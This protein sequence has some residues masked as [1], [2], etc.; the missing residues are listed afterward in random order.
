M[1]WGTTFLDNDYTDDSGY[2]NNN[3]N[4]PFSMALRS[5]PIFVDPAL[6]D[7]YLRFSSWHDL[8]TN[9]LPNGD[10]TY[11]DCAYLRVRS[12]SSISGLASSN[13]Q[14]LAFTLPY[15][16]G[17]SAS[18]GFHLRYDSPATA[19]QISNDCYGIPSNNYGLAGTSTTATNADG[20]AELAANLAIYSNNY[21]EIEFV[22]ENA[23]TEQSVAFTGRS[24]WYIDDFQVGESYASFGEMTVNYIQPP[25]DFEDKQPDGYGLLFVDSHVPGDSDLRIDIKDAITSQDIVTDKGPLTNLQG[26]VIELWDIDVDTH[27]FISITFKFYSDSIGVSTPKLFGYNIGTRIG[28]TFNDPS[29]DRNLNITNGEWIFDSVNDEVNSTILNS[30]DFGV[31]FTKPIYAINYSFEG[32]CELFNASLYSEELNQTFNS[33]NLFGEYNV[34][35]NTDFY[36]P[37][38]IYSFEFRFNLFES[39]TIENIWIDLHFGHHGEDPTIDFGNDGELDWGFIEPAQGD[40]GRQNR[41]WSGEVNGISQSNNSEKISLDVLTGTGSGGFFLLPFNAEVETFNME[42]FGGSIS[43]PNSSLAYQLRLSIGTDIIPLGSIQNNIND[44]DLIEQKFYFDAKIALQEKMTNLSTPIFKTDSFGTQWVRI[45]FDIFQPDSTNGGSINLDNLD[46]I[47]NYNHT[48]DQSNGFDTFLREFVAAEAQLVSDG[49]DIDFPVTTS[50]STGGAIKF[51]NLLI[52]SAPGYESSLDWLSDSEGLYP[53][54]E[55][56]EIKTTHD[57]LPSTG[58]SLSSARLRFTSDFGG[59]SFEYDPNR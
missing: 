13:F 54:G 45:G 9:I 39:C 29:F 53:N 35:N 36:I 56:Y 4:S 21:V 22:L 57:V 12:A 58:S 27:P 15:S 26:Q 25:T 5:P 52:Q 30:E 55:V 43:S 19:D 40:F 17:I 8:R 31:E 20:W 1:C 44:Y 10:Y 42:V 47:Y 51:S 14:F 38:P 6:N 3:V 23:D 33:S 18:D 49:S 46:V 41:F 7:T 59:L 24:G 11:S 34:T 2:S 16:T 37:L 48:F 32:K 28:N 50:S